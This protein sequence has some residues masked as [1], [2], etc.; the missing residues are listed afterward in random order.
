MAERRSIGLKSI[1]VGEIAVDGG[2][3]T[4]LAALG[5]TFEGT[6]TL[7]QEDPEVTSFYAEENDDPV[8][9][10]SA[11]GDTK[12]EFAIMDFTPS[13]MAEVLGGTVTGTGEASVWNA[14]D[15][16]PVIEQSI[17]I[18]TKKNV[19][20]QIPRAKI[21]AKI[22]MNLGKKEMS[23]IRIVATVLKPTKIGAAPIMV[24]KAAE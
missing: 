3:G 2:M 23:L 9:L 14:P 16:L 1:K 8:E 15:N 12:L 6:A 18:V 19:R 21:D 11:R 7:T 4:T 20:I 24:D 13:V 22:D 17:E 10:M 5:L